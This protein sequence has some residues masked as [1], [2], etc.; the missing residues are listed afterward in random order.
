MS[1]LDFCQQ[2]FCMRLIIFPHW[3]Q[4]EIRSR[5]A[6]FSMVSALMRIR[7][8]S[9]FPT[10]ID[11]IWPSRLSSDAL[12]FHRCSG[13]Q[14]K[15]VNATFPGHLFSKK[16]VDQAMTSRLHFRL[17]SLR[18]DVDPEM[19]FFGRAILHGLVMRVQMRVIMNLQTNWLQ[20]LRDLLPIRPYHCKP[21][22]VLTLKRIASSI[23]V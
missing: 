7:L 23:G 20:S 10:L 16:I 17:E 21:L 6:I 15:G 5:G 3:T 13:L 4:G 12:L 8:W 2:L 19:R 1:V 9:C 22:E 14:L 11:E 18:N